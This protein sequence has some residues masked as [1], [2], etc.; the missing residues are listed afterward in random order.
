MQ[1]GFSYRYAWLKDAINIHIR[2]FP[3]DTMYFVLLASLINSLESYLTPTPQNMI[4][5]ILFVVSIKRLFA[6]RYL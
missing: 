1:H 6:K 5:E 4:D 2:S 3:A